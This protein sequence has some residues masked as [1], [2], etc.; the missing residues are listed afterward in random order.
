MSCYSST[1][2]PLISHAELAPDDL[3]NCFPVT[4]NRA[5]DAANLNLAS[6]L[7]C[8]RNVADCSA[9]TTN[10]QL[11]RAYLLSSTPAFTS[12]WAVATHRPSLHD[13]KLWSTKLGD[14]ERPPT[15]STG[16][17]RAP[18]PPPPYGPAAHVP[19][20]APAG[21]GAL[22]PQPSSEQEQVL[23]QLLPSFVLSRW[24]S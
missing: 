3:I 10:N 21:T 1:E 9:S 17:L 4:P 16:T 23:E 5:N 8:G 11:A 7:R 2:I 15:S 13:Q 14:V 18:K 24:S 22:D 12:A 19:G 20:W 6:G